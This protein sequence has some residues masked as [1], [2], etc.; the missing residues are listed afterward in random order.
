MPQNT[1]ESGSLTIREVA[2]YLNVTEWTICRLVAARNVSAFQV[3]ET[4]RF[5]ATDIGGRIAGQSKKVGGT[6]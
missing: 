3:G 2:G 5:L 6:D 1:S 4:W